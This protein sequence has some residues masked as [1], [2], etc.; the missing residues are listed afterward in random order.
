M[1]QLGRACPS[2]HR[3]RDARFDI[4]PDV[5]TDQTSAHDVREGYIP[6]G[7]TVDSARELRVSDPERYDEAVLDSMVVHVRAILDL[8]QRGAI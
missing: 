4:V 6:A 5:I 2:Q 8:Q 1:P 3:R 7:H